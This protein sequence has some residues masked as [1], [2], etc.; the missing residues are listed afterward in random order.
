MLRHALPAALVLVLVPASLTAQASRSPAGV[1]LDSIE[2]QWSLGHYPEALT[3]MEAVLG[4]GPAAAVLERLALLTGE[5]FH[6]DS[7]APDGREVQWS[8]DGRFAAFAS[9]TGADRKVHLVSMAGQ[10][11]P[12]TIP[13]RSLVFSPLGT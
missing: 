13:G 6:T 5:L 9:G 10:R 3:R 8:R 7:L 4:G 2:H 1:V 11:R 12:T